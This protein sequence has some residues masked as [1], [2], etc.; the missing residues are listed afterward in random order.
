MLRLNQSI[1]YRED[2]ITSSII[3]LQRVQGESYV[4][5]E[6][7]TVVKSRASEPSSRNHARGKR[8][9][10]RCIATV[11][12]HNRGSPRT[13]NAMACVSTVTSSPTGAPPGG[14]RGRDTAQHLTVGM[15]AQR[16]VT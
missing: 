11:Q 12:R 14:W 16:G 8:R 10:A 7:N 6:I 1:V 13:Y 15:C 5:P 9:L 3:G 4:D 2:R